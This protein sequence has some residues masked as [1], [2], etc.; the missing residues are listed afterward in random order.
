[1]QRMRYWIFYSVCYKAGFLFSFVCHRAV[2]VLLYVTKPHCCMLQYVT[3]PDF[4]MLYA[5]VCYKTWFLYA[6]CCSM[7]QNLTFVCCMLQYVTKPDFCML[8]YV[9]KP[10]CFMLCAAEPFFKHAF[11]C[12]AEPDYCFMVEQTH[13][14][15]QSLF[16]SP[17]LW[18]HCP[19]VEFHWPQ[20]LI[21]TYQSC[22]LIT[23]MFVSP[24]HGPQSL[25]TFC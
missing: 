20:S 21:T 14:P 15:L 4:C 23:V 19:H 22:S 6:V 16:S 13:M 7:L 25:I 11:C 8:Q 9:T 2:F 24:V 12:V 17:I 18:R 5:A 1:M 3:K 10:D